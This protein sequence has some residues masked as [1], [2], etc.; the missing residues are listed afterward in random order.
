MT[1]SEGL[2]D[3]GDLTGHGNPYVRGSITGVGTSLGG[4]LHTLPF[5]IPQYRTALIPAVAVVAGFLA[6]FASITLAA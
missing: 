3:M 6:S 2:S 4:V 1:F 5:L